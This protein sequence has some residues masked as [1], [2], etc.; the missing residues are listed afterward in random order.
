MFPSQIEQVL[1]SMGM[2]PNYQ[3]IVD[4]INSLDKIEI[5]VEIPELLFS[6]TIKG[7]ENIGNKISE[8]IHS[9]LNISAKIK[10]VEPG[11]IPRVDGKSKRVIDRRS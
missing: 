2:E 11:S 4:R 5:C 9:T 1:L 7:I 3:I 10:L 8:L 6:D